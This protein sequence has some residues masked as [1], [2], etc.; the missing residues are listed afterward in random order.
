MAVA[1]NSQNSY[2]A[3]FMA[4]ETS[5]SQ[6]TKTNAVRGENE[7]SKLLDSRTSESKKQTGSV[8]SSG[9]VNTNS[10]EY[11]KSSD[12]A[13]TDGNVNTKTEL[14]RVCE[15]PDKEQL[16]IQSDDKV[17][18]VTD[19][20]VSEGISEDTF[21]LAEKLVSGEIEIEDIPLEKLT[22]D[23]LKAVLIVKKQSKG[24]DE[25]KKDI[26]DAD[27]QAVMQE[28]AAFALDNQIADII[29]V[30][31]DA[32]P[33]D[34]VYDFIVNAVS[35]NFAAVETAVLAENVS[36]DIPTDE[37]QLDTNDGAEFRLPSNTEKNTVQT[38]AEN[39]D[40]VQ[41]SSEGTV[42]IRKV[43]AVEQKSDAAPQDNSENSS[44]LE[45]H[46]GISK[47]ISEELEMLR[48]AKL[49][50]SKSDSEQSVENVGAKEKG[51]ENVPVHTENPLS[52]QSPV[53]MT[54]SDGKL[55]EVRPSEVMSQVTKLVEQAV[56]ENKEAVE[57]SMVLN[58]EELGRITVKLVKAADGAVSVTIVAEN[59]N[60][61]RLLEQNSELMQN[62]L[63]SNGVQLENWQT[64]NEAHQETMQRNYEGSSK[65]PYYR[66]EN[67]KSDN[68]A[69][70]GNSFADII[71]AM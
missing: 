44:N 4:A 35:E 25:E 38:K 39:A 15:V 19:D 52:A 62:N 31:L 43:Q 58:P 70:E 51:S 34:E 13:A 42:I 12:Y 55:F 2:R 1:F 63:R 17:E 8:N 40:N 56:S 5:A 3:D 16:V 28:N 68:D 22:F 61:Q 49:G 7:F 14:E 47:E 32:E 48:N 24:N 18:L 67:E 65:N 6:R 21:E 26:S 46:S 64:V 20:A 23:L 53:V 71:A 27:I 66:E 37:I 69:P 10:T 45:R 54:S 41:N 11:A 57:Y 29:S 9:S 60:T 30:I 36:M 59:S 33:N 50:K